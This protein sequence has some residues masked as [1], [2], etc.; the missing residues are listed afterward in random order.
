VEIAERFASKPP[1]LCKQFWVSQ[2]ALAERTSLHR[3]EISK[4]EHAERLPRID[5]LVKL[6]GAMAIPAER[7][8]D[9]IAWEPG[10]ARPG[11]SSW[12]RGGEIP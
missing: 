7:L 1:A 11:A 6:A 3:T 5:I 4:L 12:D 2:E 8:L 9:G 10:E